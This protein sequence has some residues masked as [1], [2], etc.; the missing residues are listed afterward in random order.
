MSPSRIAI[1]AVI[2]TLA[3]PA[4]AEF[5]YAGSPKFGEF[6]VNTKADNVRADAVARQTSSLDANAA[7]AGP[8]K[9]PFKGGIGNRAP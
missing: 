8:P 4:Y 7:I 3:S 6:Y 2:A 9:S 1:V 5:R